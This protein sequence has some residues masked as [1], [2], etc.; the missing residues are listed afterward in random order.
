MQSNRFRGQSQVAAYDTTEATRPAGPWDAAAVQAGRFL[1]PFQSHLPRL[2]AAVAV[3]LTA[4]IL[5]MWGGYALLTV[6]ERSD[7]IAGARAEGDLV[8]RAY[9]LGHRHGTLAARGLSGDERTKQS[10]DLH[11][12]LETMQQ[13]IARDVY[14]D[15]RDGAL[16]EGG[17]LAGL[18]LVLTILGLW[19]ISQLRVRETFEASLRAARD[20]AEAGNRAKSEFLANMSHEIRTPMNGILGMTGLLLD[21]ALDEEQRRFAEVVRESGEGLLTV[22]NDILDISKL[23]AGKLELETIEFDL[24]NTV[25]SAVVLMI[26]RAREKQIDIAMYIE[27][28]AA[29]TYRGD[30]NRIRQILLNLIGNAIKFTEKGGVSIEVAVRRDPQQAADGALVPLRFEVR[31]TGIGMPESVRTRLFQKFAQADS[32][33]TRRFG[34]TGLGLA[35]CKELVDLMGGT[36]TA[37]SRLGEGSIFAFEVSLPKSGAGLIDYRALP[38]QLKSLRALLVDDIAMN[39]EIL[40]RQLAALG[41]AI[42]KAADGFAAIAELERGWHQGRPYDVVFLDQM[43]PGLS[44]LDTARRIRQNPALAETRLVLVTSAGRGDIPRTD[45]ALDAVLEK[46]VRQHDL[47]DALVNLYGRR[48]LPTRPP[49][50]QAGKPPQAEATLP[51]RNTLDVL[52]AEDNKINQQFAVALLGKA[53]HRVTLADNGHA[54]VDAVRAHDFDVVLMDIQMPQL[55]GMEAMRQIRALPE[56]KRSVPIIAMTA[57]AMAGVREQYLAAGMNAYVSKPIRPELLMRELDAIAGRAA[58]KPVDGHV[59]APDPATLPPVLETGRLDEL[60][61][62][63]PPAALRELLL[64]TIE[65]VRVRL[66]A[67]EKAHGTR[68]RVVMAQDAHVVV[69]TAGNIGAARVSALARALEQECRRPDGRPLGAAVAALRLAWSEA[70]PPLGAWIAAH[71]PADPVRIA[72]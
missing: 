19:L 69:G 13:T 64:A 27:P 3:L 59:T 1:R 5:G 41:I 68:D 25:E 62:V 39:L 4:S 8:E 53:G 71:A 61:T 66:G 43:M 70:T 9:D 34:G 31:D 24:V 51:R 26:G 49:A 36:I 72:S 2:S 40:G 46:P 12:R 15:W 23:E 6:R 67:I 52:V 58:P 7:A 30:P 47:F 17:G 54:A 44:G 57:H 22:V 32:S 65:D 37:S 18:T 50:P 11:A 35:I 21:T 20:E 45:S 63:L 14:A 56:P 16:L 60:H 38:E 33:V 28:E 42:Y 10:R 55:G 29:G 48:H